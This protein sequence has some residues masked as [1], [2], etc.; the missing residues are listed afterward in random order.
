[1]QSSHVGMEPGLFR[2][3][4]NS[5]RERGVQGAVEGG[6]GQPSPLQLVRRADRTTIR[7]KLSKDM[8]R[9]CASEKNS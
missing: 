7:L 8:K 5:E 2:E 6:R 9:A 3:T 4:A 1:M